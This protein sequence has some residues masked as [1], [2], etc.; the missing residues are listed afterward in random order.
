VKQTL[1]SG[2]LWE[3]PPGKIVRLKSFTGDQ[4]YSIDLDNRTCTCDKFPAAN[5]IC[6][7]LNALGIYTRSRPFVA[8]SHP[9]FSQALSGMVKSIRLRF[10]EDAI[11]WL[12]YLDKF[13]EP[14]SRFRTARRILIGSAEDGHSISVMEHVV[15]SF[16]RISKVQAN[17][18]DLAT[19]VVRI[20]KVP[21]WWHPSTGGHDY[22]YSGMLGHRKLEYL[23]AT[24]TA[25]SL[26]GLIERGIARQEKAIALA[27]VMGLSKIRMGASRQAGLLST[28][29]KAHRHNLAERLA[30]V[31]LSARSALSSDNNFL[32]QAAWML[33]GGAC[34]VVDA[35]YPVASA[36]VS[37]LIEKAEARWKDPQPIPGWCCDGVHSAGNDVRFM[38][39]WEHMYAVCRAFSHYGRVNPED[40]WIP[41]FLS[42]DGLIVGEAAEENCNQLHERSQS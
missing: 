5:E 38:G 16:K 31:H 20:C 34:P 25:E 14:E 37:E 2:M 9:T 29:A 28:L 4:W 21:N 33:S 13:R 40:E 1:F 39:S 18:E 7:H 8:R 22:I 19:E 26:S 30:R 11:Y 24:A 36:E 10:I 6:R 23:S 42:Y 15:G 41:N 35:I 27:G 17:I 12:V 32:C 3:I